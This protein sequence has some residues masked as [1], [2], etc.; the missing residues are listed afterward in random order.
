ML[1]KK[2]EKKNLKLKAAGTEIES[3]CQ[4]IA[5]FHSNLY[6][7]DREYRHFSK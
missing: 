1:L 4:I 5:Q 6:Q 7:K 2:L 3:I